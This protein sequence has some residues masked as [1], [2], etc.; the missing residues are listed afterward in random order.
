[1]M[2]HLPTFACLATS[3][4]LMVPVGILLGIPFPLAIRYLIDSPAHRAFA[5]AVNG[6]A[7]VLAAIA[8]AQIVITWGLTSLLGCAVVA[9][10]VAGVALLGF[11]GPRGQGVK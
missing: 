8:S 11:K 5:W 6:S 2:M 3:S 1:M 9:Y 10:A 4:L 7:S